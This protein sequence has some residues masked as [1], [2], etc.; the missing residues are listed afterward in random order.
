MLC[1]A[2]KDALSGSLSPDGSGE[3]FS[4]DRRFYRRCFIEYMKPKTPRE[5]VIQP[6]RT[7]SEK[8]L[9]ECR[10]GQVSSC[11]GFSGMIERYHL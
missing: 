2:G 8:P 5:I 11:G 4:L 3:I 1:R 6:P 7:R 10:S 9:S